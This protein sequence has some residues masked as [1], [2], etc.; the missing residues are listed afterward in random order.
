MRKGEE[1]GGS[2]RGELAALLRGQEGS[3]IHLCGG[4]SWLVCG[5]VK[6][7]EAFICGEG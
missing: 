3:G 5:G 6:R 2:S 4:V 1:G 7:V